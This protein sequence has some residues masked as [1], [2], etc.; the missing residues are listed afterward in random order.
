MFGKLNSIHFVGIGGVGMSGLALVLKNMGYQ[1]TGSDLAKTALTESLENKG[2]K[3]FYQHD[4]ENCIN[5]SVVVYS[6]AINQNNPEIIYAKEKKIPVIQRAE[7]LAELMRMKYSVAVS[8]THGKTTVTSMVGSMLDYAGYNPTVIIGGKVFGSD[9]GAK[10][11]TS[12][13]MVAEADESDRSFLLLYPTIAVVTNI[14][15]EHLDYYRNITE[16][17][18]AFVKFINKIPFFGTAILCNDC[19][20]V[21]K[22]IPEI[23]RDYITYGIKNTAQIHAENIQLHDFYSLFNLNYNHK[24][25]NFKINLAGP[26]NIQNALATICVGL[27]L[28]IP[29][30]SI[31]GALEKFKGVHRR[32][33]RKGEKRHITIFDDYGH[34]PTEIQVTLKALR[35][36]Y[37]CRRIIT[38][39]QP[40]RYS[41]TQS[42]ANSFG[43]CFNDTD[44]LVITK[45][46][47]AS[48]T[49]IPGVSSDIIINSISR[50]KTRH[51]SVIYKENFEEIIKF[52]LNFI[53]PDD[54]IIT[55]GAGNIWQIGEELLK[56]L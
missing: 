50:N 13:F 14:E 36:A 48:E 53:K 11:G 25:Y 32:L 5:A 8:G 44:V 12:Q 35:H 52:I 54:I 33:E 10:L 34:H 31:A 30:E 16:L 3:I 6:S 19:K 51:P 7:M 38:I 46:Y 17:K 20:T 15:R 43:K 27:K 9:A 26:H 55:L 45:I 1:I 28:E 22:I 39:F 2:I 29:F 40:H 47:A 49:P 4:Q 18:N 23:K 56:Q 21:E 37:P 24:I 41:R 42:L